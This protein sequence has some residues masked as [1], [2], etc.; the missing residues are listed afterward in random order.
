MVLPLSSFALNFSIGLQNVRKYSRVT[1]NDKG[2]SCPGAKVLYQH[3][4]IL[5]APQDI[6]SLIPPRISESSWKGSKA[7]L[8]ARLCRPH[9]PLVVSYRAYPAE[10]HAKWPPLHRTDQTGYRLS[11]ICGVVYACSEMACSF[12]VV[13]S[14]RSMMTALPMLERQSHIKL[15][16]DV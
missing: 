2:K 5:L 1:S 4:L 13:R 15:D 6:D 9:N 7:S 12:E 16:Q 10:S 11:A 3:R 8:P 14:T